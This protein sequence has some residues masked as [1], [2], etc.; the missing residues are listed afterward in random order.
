[1]TLSCPPEEGAGANEA[2]GS[3]NIEAPKGAVVV[4]L[5][6]LAPPNEKPVAAG[7]AKGFDAAGAEVFEPPKENRPAAGAAIGTDDVTAAGAADP[8]PKPAVALAP[9]NPNPVVAVV[10]G[11]AAA[12]AAPKKPNAEVAAA[13]AGT[14]ADPNA[15]P[16]VAV[17]AAKML[18]GCEA[19][20][21]VVK[22]LAVQPLRGGRL[23]AA[24][25][26]ADCAAAPKLNA[27]G[28]T[29]V[30]LRWAA[31]GESPFDGECADSTRTGLLAASWGA[32][33]AFPQPRFGVVA[34]AASA[35]ADAVCAVKEKPLPE[36]GAL[37]QETAE[38]VTA[39]AEYHE[40]GREMSCE[41]T[42]TLQENWSV[43]LECG[44]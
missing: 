2:V 35:V 42:F 6:A 33:V 36:A 43:W 5:V 41:Q 1:M 13:G 11:A 30:L 16:T 22:R 19:S 25:A 24:V 12:G 20:G 7:C 38:P 15:T 28:G 44:L 17:G 26:F 9:P 3:E 40:R 31:S 4:A 32:A 29:D 10:G 27:D 34:A 21:T 8:N 18:G 14:A 37:P 39:E 23:G